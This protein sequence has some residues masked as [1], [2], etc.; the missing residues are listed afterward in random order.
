MLQFALLLLGCALSIYLWGVD[1]II[2]S[3][4]LVLTAFG[5]ILLAFV[6]VAGA[7]SVSCPYQTPGAQILRYLWQ[8]VPS[9]LTLFAVKGPAA[10]HSET[11]LGPEQ[12]LDLE[13]TDLDFR[14]IS[15]ILQTSLDQRISQLTLE[16][17]AS[18]LMLPGFKTVVAADCFKVFIGCLRVTNNRAV[19]IR[20]YEQLAATAAMCLLHAI[21]RLLREDPRSNILK[22]MNQHYNRI[23]PPTADFRGLHSRH[24]IHVVHSFF[25]RRDRPKGLSWKGVDPSAPGNI[26]LAQYLAGIAGYCYTRPW[27]GGRKKVPRWVLRFSLHSLLRDPEPPV[28]V[29]T[30]CLKVV[31]ID[32]GCDLSEDDVRN[33]DERYESLAQLHSLSC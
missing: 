27:L 24:T 18:I 12:T 3:V 13:A 32:L 1:K 10:Q 2:A 29:I 22:D 26:F 30:D 21:S 33:P 28:S 25:H 4:I 6:V 8:K 16:Y 11:H 15:W 31:A 7:A 17:L 19:V 5:V 23:L 14:C 9:R 20:G